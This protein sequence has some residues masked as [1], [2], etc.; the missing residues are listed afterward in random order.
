MYNPDEIFLPPTAD[1]DNEL[2]LTKRKNNGE[3]KIRNYL[4][5]Y[6]GLVSQVDYGIGLIMDELEKSG[7]LE[8]TIITVP[9]LCIYRVYQYLVLL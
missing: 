1:T 5:K 7:Q 2:F 9:L 4:A 8:N 6:L 3:E